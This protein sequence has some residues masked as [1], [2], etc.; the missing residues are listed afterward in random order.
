LFIDDEDMMQYIDIT[1][2]DL[3]IDWDENPINGQVNRE[4]IPTRKCVIDDFGDP[5]DEHTHHKWELLESSSIICIDQTD[6][7]ELA[8]YGDITML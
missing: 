3:D 7:Q 4:R 5:E 1:F 2:A 8:L 6:N